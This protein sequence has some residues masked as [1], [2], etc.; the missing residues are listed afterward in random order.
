MKIL[1]MGG[2]GT[3]GSAITELMRD[4]HEVITVGKNSGD[5]QADIEDKSS[6][7]ALFSKVGSVDAI[8]SAAGAGMIAG[9]DDANDHPYDLVLKSKVMG[10]INLARV[11]VKHLSPGGTIILTS[12]QAARRPMP[13]TTAIAMGCAAIEAFVAT[14]ALELVNGQRIN[15]VSPPFV[16]ETMEQFGMDSSTGTPALT[17]ADAYR[18]FVVSKDNGQVTQFA[19]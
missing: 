4:D 7:E 3:I 10:Q 8:I 17:V 12:G 2:T 16:K 19:V 1:V 14:A 6:I 9:F 5:L 11:G 18:A 13:Q 15:V